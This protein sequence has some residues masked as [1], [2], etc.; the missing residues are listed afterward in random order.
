M[1]IQTYEPGGG[2]D[3]L[4]SCQ[5]AIALAKQHGDECRFEFNDLHMTAHP[6]SDPVKLAQDYTDKSNRR[7]EKW[8]A[9]PEYAEQQARFKEEE[10]EK[11]RVLNAWLMQSPAAMS[12]KDSDFWK[13]QCDANKEGYGG[14]II[15]YTQ[16]WARVMEGRISQGEQLEKI[17]DECSHI[18]D[19]DGLTGFMY[20]CA[21]AILAKVWIHGEDLRR[22]HNKTTQLRDEGDKANE[23][24]GVLNPALLTIG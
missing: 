18:A 11:N 19:V 8:L 17:A 6:D 22:W 1:S 5:K 16:T 9:S 13:Q 7:H 14:A 2:E 23:N 15:I 3:I 10:K 12:L 21:V 24:G 4:T 20:G